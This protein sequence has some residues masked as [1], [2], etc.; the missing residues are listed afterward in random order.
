MKVVPWGTHLVQLERFGL[1]F[2]V[3]CYFVREDDGLTLVDA[4]VSGSASGILRAARVLGA[5]I[6]RLVLT[7][8]H[9]DHAGALDALHEALPEAE[10]LLGARDARITRGDRGLDPDE[11]Q[12]PIK[13]G[14]PA[15][16]TRPTREL[17]GGDRVGSLEVVP[18]PGHT[19]GH[20]AFFD[21]REGNLLAG[22]AFQTRAGL[23]V[24]GVVRPLFPFPAL[25]TWHKPTALRSAAALRDLRPARLAAGHGR[26]LEGPGPALDAALAEAQRKLA[27]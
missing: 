10:V 5:P 13:G 21:P 20:L 4:A 9:V 18:S 6:R 7:H 19:P 16:T 26:V 23:A 8:P 22:D 25:S 17:R 24:A 15:L 12:A 11:P 2:P 1:L 14:W 27:A 3:S